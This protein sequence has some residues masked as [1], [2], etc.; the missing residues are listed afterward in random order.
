MNLRMITAKTVDQLRA[1]SLASARRRQHMNLHASHNEPVQ[2][3]LNAIQI[4]SYI[5]PHRHSI[6]PKIESL[7]ALA[8]SFVLFVFDENG[9]V[10]R[11]IRLVSEKY[12]HRAETCL[13][14]ELSPGTWHT[15]LAMEPDSIL[16]ELKAGPFDTNA[17]KEYAPWAPDEGTEEGCI[18]LK[19]LREMSQ[20]IL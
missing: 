18:Y 6:D 17:A 8:G 2:R 16:L 1:E 5:R 13:G 19:K 11:I 7:F 20:F 9:Q 12:I 14:V 15:V 3:L 4:D 10:A